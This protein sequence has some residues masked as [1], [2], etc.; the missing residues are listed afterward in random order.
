MLNWYR[1]DDV[2]TAR[3]WQERQGHVTVT[4]TVTANCPILPP[5]GGPLG[6]LRRIHK[7]RTVTM[8]PIRVSRIEQRDARI[9]DHEF[10]IV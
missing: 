1:M 3:E 2:I 9:G 6:C 5:D 8:P 4:A 10:T 7:L